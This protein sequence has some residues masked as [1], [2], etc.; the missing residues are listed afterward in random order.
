MA[1]TSLQTARLWRVADASPL[2]E[3]SGHTDWVRS[4]SFSPD[5]TMVATGSADRT[6][7]VWGVADGAKLAVFEHGSGVRSCAFSPNGT[8]LASGT[9]DG[10]VYLW[11]LARHADQMVITRL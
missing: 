8:L 7:C 3:L 2:R 9:A 5:G 1:T 11:S 10:R 4:C 6:T